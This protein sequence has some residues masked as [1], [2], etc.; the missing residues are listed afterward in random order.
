MP[1]AKG[2]LGKLNFPNAPFANTITHARMLPKL[3][4]QHIALLHPALDIAGTNMDTTLHG[5][6]H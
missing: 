3:I 6:E 2:A 4:D 5:F 1:F